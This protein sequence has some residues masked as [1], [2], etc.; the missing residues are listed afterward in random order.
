MD[1]QH[2]SKII[3]IIR[4]GVADPH[5]GLSDQELL[6]LYSLCD[7]AA[8]GMWMTKPN[9]DE[10]MSE[11]LSYTEV[12]A[13]LLPVD[14]PS[15]NARLSTCFSSCRIIAV[16]FCGAYGMFPIQIDVASFH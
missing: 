15:A 12:S 1:I 9:L 2:A 10:I 13:S 7:A 3:E 11:N 16:G 5:Y 4:H 6:Q 14:D 8:Q